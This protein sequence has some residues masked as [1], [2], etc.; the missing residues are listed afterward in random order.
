M[1]KI[2]K[3]DPWDGKDGQLPEEEDIDLSD[4]ELDD[5]RIEL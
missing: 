1:P 2:S 3:I 4:V 5:M